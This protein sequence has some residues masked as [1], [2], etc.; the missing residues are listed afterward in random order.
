MA[1]INDIRALP[2]EV[3][4]TRD[5]AQIAAALPV[6]VSVRP[7]MISERGVLAALPVPAGDVFLSALEAFAAAALPDGHPLVAYHGTI[8]RGVGWLKGEGLDLGDPLT[9][10]L[11]DTLAQV[12]VVDA[13]SVAALKA[14]A[15][16]PDPIDEMTVR[17][18]CWSDEG[19]WLP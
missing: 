16:T 18:A 8:K 1:L 17:Q 10:T 7:H 12:G 6:I 15:E 2:Q 5:T 14:L 19:V 9:R 11:L 13:S 4:D 3:L